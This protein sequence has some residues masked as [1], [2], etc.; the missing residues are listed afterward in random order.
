[1]KQVCKLVIV[2]LL[3]GQFRRL[4][5]RFKGIVD[6]SYMSSS[7]TKSGGKFKDFPRGDHCVLLTKFVSHS[8]EKAAEDVFGKNRVVLVRGGMTS[9]VAAIERISAKYKQRKK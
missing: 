6:L 1:M 3:G 5:S 4:E 9:V 7:E 2:G 8:S